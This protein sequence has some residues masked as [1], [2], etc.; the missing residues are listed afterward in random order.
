[1]T[2]SPV[3]APLSTRTPQPVPWLEKVPAYVPGKPAVAGGL[4]L[5]ANEAVECSPHVARA[6]QDTQDWNRYPDPLAGELRSQLARHHGVQAEQI[7]V[8]NGSDELVQLLISAYVG[9]S[10]TVVAA[11]PPYAM[12]RIAAL[13]AGANFIGVPLRDWSHDLATMAAIQA[14]LVY[15][16][17]PHNPTGTCFDATSVATFARDAAAT[18]VVIDEAYI[19]FAEPQMR[20]EV[21]QL[22]ADGR[23]AVLRTFS[24]AYGL[25]GCRVGYVI[26]SESIIAQLRRVR[27]PFSVTAPGQVAASA[28]L[29]DRDYLGRH[30]AAVRN[31]R[32]ALTTTLRSLGCEVPDSHANFVLAAGLD[33]Q[34]TVDRLAERGISVR[35]G[36]SLGVPGSVR[37]TV[38][39]EQDLPRVF[40]ALEAALI[41]LGDT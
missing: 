2:G 6:L 13:V 9:H 26:A 17:N 38:P 7:L 8:S 16:V 5:A 37:I 29:A 34:R 1:M 15:L 25:A 18:I 3:T 20:G 24:K 23:T 10:G 11:D 41:G 4:A 39:R 28:A 35:A 22:I 27:A 36:S 31:A 32:A 12:S 33:E 30:V 40:S 14:E 21:S 19:D